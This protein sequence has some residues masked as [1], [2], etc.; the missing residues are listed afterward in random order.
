[1]NS[2]LKLLMFFLIIVFFS[3]KNNSLQYGYMNTFKVVLC[4]EIS[5]GMYSRI[6]FSFENKYYEP[7]IVVSYKNTQIDSLFVLGSEGYLSYSI[8]DLKTDTLFFSYINECAHIDFFKNVFICDNMIIDNGEYIRVE[9]IIN[10]DF[11]CFKG[12]VLIV[13]TLSN[14]LDDKSYTNT[15][16]D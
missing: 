4:N 2:I 7:K 6:K 1:M 9:A 13:Y 10:E 14:N 11:Y 8:S 3:C 16:T 12:E 5:L 15:T